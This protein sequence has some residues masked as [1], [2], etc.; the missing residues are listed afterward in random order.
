MTVYLFHVVEE[1]SQKSLFL[2]K[3]E[4]TFKEPVLSRG[5]DFVGECF[6]TLQAWFIL[7]RVQHVK[8]CIA[9]QGIQAKISLITLLRAAEF[10]SCKGY[11]PPGAKFEPA[12]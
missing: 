9:P 11:F 10:R 8:T 5:C 6:R 12:L 3:F 1:K 7:D 2:C 4:E